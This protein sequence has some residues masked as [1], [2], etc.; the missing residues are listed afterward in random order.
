MIRR[1]SG[2]RHLIAGCAKPRRPLQMKSSGLTTMPSLPA[3]V[4]STHHG[5]APPQLVLIVETDEAIGRGQQQSTLA[6]PQSLA[7]HLHVPGV[8]L[9]SVDRTFGSKQM[10]R[11]QFQ[12][13]NGCHGP[14]IVPIC[15]AVFQNR[16]EP[17]VG[18]R[19]QLMQAVD[20]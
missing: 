19:R 18:A 6:A 9:V 10:E 3:A 17:L 11:S 13:L 7:K 12:V 5:V 4:I 2:P 14:A 8:L 16:F 15:I 20:A 1:Y